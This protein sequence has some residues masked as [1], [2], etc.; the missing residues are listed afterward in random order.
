MDEILVTHLAL[1]FL[2]FS[3]LRGHKGGQMGEGWSQKVVSVMKSF[4]WKKTA[5]GF[6]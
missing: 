5:T 1:H 4:Q 6:W 2:T 3:G